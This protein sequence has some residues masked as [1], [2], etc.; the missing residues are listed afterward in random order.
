[1]SPTFQL[2]PQAAARIRAFYDHWDRLRGGRECPSRGDFDPAAVPEFLEYIS[3][4]DVSPETPRF[5]YRL[6]GTGVV[7]LLGKELTGQP[8]GTGVKASEID[9]VL[10][11]YQTVAATM[12]P[13]Y[14]RDYLQEENNDF[15][16]VE[17]LMLPL[18]EDGQSVNMILVFVWP[19]PA[20]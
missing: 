7:R 16:E 18:S 12:V 1:M 3:L 20:R 19:R 9:K 14:H 13:L 8:V 4:V 10:D 6:V 5:V 15:T 2:P 11:R 17:R